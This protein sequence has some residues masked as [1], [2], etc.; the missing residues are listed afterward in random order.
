MTIFPHSQRIFLVKFYFSFF[1]PKILNKERFAVFKTPVQK[2][3]ALKELKAVAK[4]EKA[5][6]LG[7]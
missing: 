4:T 7:T 5:G 1:L 6:C 3:I 2:V